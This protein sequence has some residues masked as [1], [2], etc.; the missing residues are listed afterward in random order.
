MWEPGGFRK[1]LPASGRVW[2]TKNGRAN[3][4]LPDGLDED[5][6]MP[7]VGHDV[8]RMMTLRSNDQFN[9]TVYG[10]NDRFRGVNGTR[11]VVLMNRD[12]IERLGLREGENIKLATASKDG[13]TRELAGLRVTPYDIPAGCI[14]AYYPEANVLMP[15]DH[16]AK[17]SM[18]P[19]AKSVPVTVQ[20]AA[21]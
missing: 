9:T 7:D 14:G 15:L 5:L 4:I 20:R 12:D 3:F 17:G 10:Y 11:M 19:A 8:L 18:T 16:Y 6:D 13:I 2:Q 1:P 21:A